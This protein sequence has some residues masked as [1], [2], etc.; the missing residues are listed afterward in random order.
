MSIL[1]C[2]L[3]AYMYTFLLKWEW[4]VGAYIG[5]CLTLLETATLISK[6]VVSFQRQCM[7]VPLCSIDSIFGTVDLFVYSHS[8]RHPRLVPDLRGKHSVLYY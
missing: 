4:N 3:N 8:G 1:V 2:I 6:M 5:V 7:R